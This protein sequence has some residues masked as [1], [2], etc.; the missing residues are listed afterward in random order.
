MTKRV[1]KLLNTI[2]LA[3]YAT[4]ATSSGLFVSKIKDIFGY[5]DIIAITAIV[6]IIIFLV[7]SIETFIIFAVN[8][9]LFLRRI[10]SGSQFIEG[11]WIDIAIEGN[12]L[13]HWAELTITFTDGKLSYNGEI[14]YKPR[15]FNVY[16]STF[17]SRELFLNEKYTLIT[18]YEG[19]DQNK[20][21]NSSGLAQ[22]DFVCDRYSPSKF[23]GYIND[24]VLSKTFG[25]VGVK[26]PR[27]G[28]SRNRDMY[29]KFVRENGLSDFAFNN[30]DEL[31]PEFYHI[32]LFF[33]IAFK[34]FLQFL[35]CILP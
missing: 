14:H 12:E 23:N 6:L 7:K 30:K 3:I 24:D 13:H 9:S 32:K 34:S 33:I 10:C 25:L 16:P 28:N 35:R 8:H 1:N 11:Q 21:K 31:L 15:R 20:R 2:S 22:Y 4:A 26:R 29:D 5:G 27:K 17:K 19:F 18:S